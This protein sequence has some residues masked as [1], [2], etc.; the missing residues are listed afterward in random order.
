MDI[1]SLANEAIGYLAP[2]M[3]FLLATGK[4]LRDKAIEKV[5]Q[6]FG[7]EG[8]RFGKSLWGKLSSKVEAKPAALEAAK[9]LAADP[10][11]ADNQ[12]SFRKELKKILADDEAL[13]SEIKQILEE[14]KAADVNVVQSG[15]RNISSV[16][17][18]IININ[19][20]GDGNKFN[21]D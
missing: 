6:N 5:G 20:T 10:N 19:I 3:P 4:T 8:F 7:E 18:H 11:N 9:D 16:G 13:A 2:A 1:T 15:D 12:A 14:A 21:K 17:D